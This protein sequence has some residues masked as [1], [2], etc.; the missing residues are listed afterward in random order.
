MGPIITNVILKT[1]LVLSL[2]NTADCLHITRKIFRNLS[3]Q[4]HQ[5]ILFENFSNFLKKLVGSKL[6][7]FVRKF[8]RTQIFLK[9]LSPGFSIFWSFFQKNLGF[10]LL[11]K[12]FLH[13]SEKFLLT[14]MLPI[15]MTSLVS[16]TKSI[17]SLH[18]TI[19]LSFW[20]VFVQWSLLGRIKAFC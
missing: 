1:R 13:P 20:F 11:W 6:L 3:R 12:R 19:Y 16:P 9:G 10:P 18:W 5:N 14:C 2:F 15:E 8:L 17:S 7:F 4:Q